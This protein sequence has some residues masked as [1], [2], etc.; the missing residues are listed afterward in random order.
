MPFT[1]NGK[2][3]KRE[4]AGKHPGEE[5]KCEWLTYS[6][7]ICMGQHSCGTLIGPHGIK[8][9]LV[10]LDQANA[11]W[12]PTGGQRCVPNKAHWALGTILD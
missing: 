4:L 7:N 8:L 11:M 10:G 3:R 2:K 5:G 9:A 1:K 6:Q 12:A